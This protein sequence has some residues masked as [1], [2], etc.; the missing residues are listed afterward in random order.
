MLGHSKTKIPRHTHTHIYILYLGGNPSQ[1]LCDVNV[2]EGSNLSRCINAVIMCHPNTSLAGS[3]TPRSPSEGK[4]AEF[5][6][7]I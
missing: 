6:L 2:G 7:N 1:V 4:Y 5:A 3:G